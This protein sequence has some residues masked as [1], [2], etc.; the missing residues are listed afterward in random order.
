PRPC[1]YTVHPARVSASANPI[2]AR[3]GPITPTVGPAPPPA[4][5]PT[6]VLVRQRRRR[7]RQ[8]ILRRAR[9]ARQSQR[10]LHLMIVRHAATEFGGP[11]EHVARGFVSELLRNQRAAAVDGAVGQ[12]HSVRTQTPHDLGHHVVGYRELGPLELATGL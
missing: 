10:G 11:A 7:E 2:P 8:Q 3:P 4:G 5:R 12:R 1:R 6:L 9:A